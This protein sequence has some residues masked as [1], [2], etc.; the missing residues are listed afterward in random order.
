V[1]W[2]LK[3]DVRLGVCNDPKRYDDPAPIRRVVVPAT[4]ANATRNV[5]IF[6]RDGA[7]IQL[8]GL[9]LSANQA[10]DVALALI[11]MAAEIRRRRLL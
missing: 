5:E 6:E 2:R 11:R 4:R 10:D 9:K 8:G 7:I 1:E 3:S